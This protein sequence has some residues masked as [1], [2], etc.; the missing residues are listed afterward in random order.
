LGLGEIADAR[1]VSVISHCFTGHLPLALALVDGPIFIKDGLP[2][3]L[4]CR[5]HQLKLL[6]VAFP[7]CSLTMGRVVH[8]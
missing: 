6:V 5:P 3:D 8:F 4:R 2:V 7:D 1:S